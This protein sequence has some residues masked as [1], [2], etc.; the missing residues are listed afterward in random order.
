MVFDFTNVKKYGLT[1][2][3]LS[4]IWTK[5][6]LVLLTPLQHENFYV[7]PRVHLKINRLKTIAIW[8][9]VSPQSKNL[10]NSHVIIQALNTT[11]L[12]QHYKDINYDHNFQM[13][14]ILC[15]IETRIHHSSIDVHK[16]INSLKYSYISIH[17]C[18]GL[19]MMYDIHMHLHSF[20]KIFS[21]GSKYITSISYINT[22]KSIHIV[23]VYR[24]HSCSIFTFS[25]NFQTMIQQS[26][27]H[28]P[29]IIMRD[30]N[31][32]ILKDNNQ[33]KEKKRT[34]IF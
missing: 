11:S 21:D 26:P 23:C 19:M 20:N 3:T 18:H 32:G 34:I 31:V 9:P 4:H 8:I 24:T 29:I 15:L 30:F 17:D 1:Y 12:H 25:N 28:C 16:F 27:E 33:K 13:S 2:T 6:K 10:H 14:H 7:D 22:R 5:E